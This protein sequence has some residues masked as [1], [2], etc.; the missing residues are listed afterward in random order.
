[1]LMT[2][3]TFAQINHGT[4]IIFNFSKNQVVVAADSRIT[5]GDPTMGPNN[6][7][8]KIVAF[9]RDLIFTSTGM[10]SYTKLPYGDT[11]ESWD[12]FALAVDAERTVPKSKMG[13]VYMG[14]VRA[15]WGE[16]VGNHWVSLYKVQPLKVLR[17]AETNGG[18]LTTGIFIGAASGKL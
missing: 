15:K 5:G 14:E 18:S 10:G 6:S 13:D 16:T 7:Q 11:I 8:C 1:M 2:Y 12:N 9:K 3:P 4:S 17:T